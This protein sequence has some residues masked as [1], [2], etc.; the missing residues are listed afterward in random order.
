M[1]WISVLASVL[2]LY[3]VCSS[4]T[5]H[6]IGQGDLV[7]AWENA[8]G[9]SLRFYADHEIKADALAEAGSGGSAK[10]AGWGTGRSTSQPM[11]RASF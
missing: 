6:V 7:G 3:A 11:T 5:R 4:E 8:D 10:V 9:D 1:A 2:L